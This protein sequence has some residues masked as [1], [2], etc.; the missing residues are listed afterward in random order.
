MKLEYLERKVQN[1]ENIEKVVSYD[2]D[3]DQADI[4]YLIELQQITA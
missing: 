1:L 4:L 3:E 2:I